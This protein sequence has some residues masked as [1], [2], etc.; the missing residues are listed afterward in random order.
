MSFQNPKAPRGAESVLAEKWGVEV[1][2]QG[3]TAVPD[4]LL[5]NMGELKISPTEMVVL[6]QLMRYWW[7]AGQLPFPSKKTL[8]Q[9]IGS[10]EKNVQKV[11][12]RLVARGLLKRILRKKASDRNDS[13]CYDL[14]PLIVRLRGLVTQDF[15]ARMRKAREQMSEPTAQARRPLYKG[16]RR[17]EKNGGF[18]VEQPKPPRPSVEYI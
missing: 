9:A 7:A 8:A 17:V 5:A 3:Y 15:E 12:G 10:S 11:V 14:E 1:I 6:L 13:N 2:G 16:S 4:V 18:N